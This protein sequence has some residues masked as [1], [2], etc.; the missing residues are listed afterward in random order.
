MYIWKLV[1]GMICVE[2]R[3]FDSATKDCDGLLN[4]LRP[5][6]VR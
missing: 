3:L 5:T 1:A 2:I 6:N 4:T